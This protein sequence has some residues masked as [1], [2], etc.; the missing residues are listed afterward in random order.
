[1][2]AVATLLGRL[3]TVSTALDSGADPAS[4]T[5]KARRF[6]ADEGLSQLFRAALDVDTDKFFDFAFD[7]LL[8]TNVVVQLPDPNKRG[9]RF[10]HGMCSRV[11]QQG[12]DNDFNHYRLELV[13]QVWRL[14]KKAQSRIFQQINVPDIL[15]AVFTGLDVVRSFDAAKFE[16]RDYCVQYHETDWDFAARLM[17]EEGI[18]F[19]FRHTDKGHQMVLANS[20]NAHQDVPFAPR[21]TFKSVTQAA[22][23]AEEFISDFGKTQEITTGK[24]TLWDNNFELPRLHLEAEQQVQESV[25]VGQVT[26]KLKFGENGKLESYTYPGEYAERFDGIGPGGVERA[27]DLQKIFDDNKRTAGIRMQQAAARAIEVR[28]A[29]TCRQLVPGFKFAVVTQPSDPLSRALRADGTYVVTSVTQTA[30]QAGERSGTGSAFTFSNTFTAIPLGLPFRPPRVT[31]KPVVPGSQ[32]ATVSGP[33]GQE[34]F[35]DKYGRVKV[36]FHW[37]REGKDDGSCSCWLR[38]ATP[39]AGRKWGMVHIPR[40][41][42]EV[43]VDFLEGDPD[44]PIV[45]GSVYNADQMPPYALPENKTQSGIKSNS[46]LGGQGSNEIRF[47]DKKGQEDIFVH[48]QRTLNTVVESSESRA[49]GGSRQ[50][51]I[52]HGESLVVKKDGRNTVIEKG[53]EQLIVKEDGRAT[54]IQKGHEELIVD[55]GDRLTTVGQGNDELRVDKGNALRQVNNGDYQVTAKTIRLEATTSITLKVGDSEIILMNDGVGVY[56]DVLKLEGAD[57]VEVKSKVIDLN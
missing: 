54:A 22:T 8:G 17:E 20:P 43:I 21:I 45:V 2:S 57:H 27:A 4:P 7:Q 18:F 5:F 33:N 41:G 23:Q 6:Q 40:I 26:H 52:Y 36:L 53:G 48:A 47:E 46:S 14:T 3:L 50:T 37:D 49:V 34:I 24:V 9:I 15:S 11:S 35:T 32:T 29:S 28:G 31:P 51:V 44:R 42:Q 39:W 10:F 30:A 1:M 38:V 55:E 19:F 25:P 13:P 56:G 12:S 16:K